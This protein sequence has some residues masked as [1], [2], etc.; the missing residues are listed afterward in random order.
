VDFDAPTLSFEGIHCRPRPVRIGGVPVWIGGKLT[1]RNLA[2]IVRWGS[3]WIPAPVDGLEAVADGVRRLRGALQ[4]AGRDPASVRVRVTPRAVR[5]AQG[6]VAVAASL[7]AGQALVE[8]GGTDVF[9]S[10]MGWCP[11]PEE[12]PAFLEELAAAHGA[13]ET[14]P[15]E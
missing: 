11:T 3:G 5:D 12:A 8:A 10:L 13:S 4:E 1:D 9:V 14:A 7:T 15:P 6:R 2:R